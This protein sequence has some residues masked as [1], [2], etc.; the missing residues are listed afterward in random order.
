MGSNSDRN[1]T[2]ENRMDQSPVFIG[3][4]QRS[5][6]SLLRALLCSHP[7]LAIFEYDLP[8]YTYFYAQYENQDITLKKIYKD[9]LDNIFKHDKTKACY[10]KV[11]Q[12]IVESKIKDTNRG[13]LTLSNIFKCFLEEYARVAGKPRWGLKTPFNEF[14]ADKIF[15][16]FPRAS[17]IH[18]IRDPRDVAL[19]YQKFKNWSNYYSFWKHINKWRE[20]TSLALRYKKKYKGQYILVR[21]EDLVVSTESTIKNICEFVGLDYKPS[22]LKMNDHFGWNGNNSSFSDFN[23]QSGI[24]SSKGVGRYRSS[25]DPFLIYVYQS[26]LKKEMQYYNYKIENFTNREKINYSIRYYYVVGKKVARKLWPFQKI[27]Q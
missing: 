6:T 25:L 14:Y 9:L 8:L 27:K 11:S 13:D 23:K 16:A 1:I 2:V 26:R 5:G 15:E 4:M 17:M 22:V 7:D 19:S 24:I 10:Y 3:G 21:Y 18:V 20:S 12:E